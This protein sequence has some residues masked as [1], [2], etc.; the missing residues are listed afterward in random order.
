MRN[1]EKENRIRKIRTLLMFAIA[2][3]D[4]YR[5]DRLKHLLKQAKK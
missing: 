3:K 1:I 5:T 4:Y 2:T